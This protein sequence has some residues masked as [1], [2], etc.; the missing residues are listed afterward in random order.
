MRKKIRTEERFCVKLVP[1][2]VRRNRFLYYF[3]GILFYCF[4]CNRIK[5]HCW[6]RTN[7]LA[8]IDGD[9]LPFART[10]ISLGECVLWIVASVSFLC[11]DDC[12]VDLFLIAALAVANNFVI[13]IFSFN[14]SS[15]TFGLGLSAIS[16][17]L[18]FRSFGSL[19]SHTQNKWRDF[20][21]EKSSPPHTKCHYAHR[22]INIRSSFAR[23][24]TVIACR[25]KR[26]PHTISCHYKYHKSAPFGF[27][28]SVAIFLGA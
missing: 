25:A 24:S 20:A 6:L 2:I 14:Q 8:H 3:A 22:L 18:Q 26:W 21:C 5:F 9:L 13:F 15:R 16:R 23:I 19:S 7:G 11:D 17:L 4:L 28:V 10:F 12:V 1:I 27:H